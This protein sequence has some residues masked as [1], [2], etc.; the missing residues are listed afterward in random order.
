MFDFIRRFV[1]Y[2]LTYTLG[3]L[4]TL[5][6]VATATRMETTSWMPVAV[7]LVFLLSLGLLP[8]FESIALRLT[9]VA[10]FGSGALAAWFLAEP[11]AASEPNER[12][13]VLVP[14]IGSIGPILCGI[15]LLLM[16]EERRC[17]SRAVWAWMFSLIAL[18][19]LVS[20]YST[21]HDLAGSVLL[22]HPSF[23]YSNDF[24]ATHAIPMRRWYQAVFYTVSAFVA[25]GLAAACGAPK[26]KRLVFA[27]IV[28]ISYAL[29]D[30]LR[31]TIEFTDIYSKR[32]IAL[33]IGCVFV[34]ALIGTRIFKNAPNFKQSEPK[35]SD[36]G[37]NL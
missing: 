1:V 16:W 30:E 2:G 34:A 37:N 21:M 12:F 4:A 31:N 22:P 29:F 18:G 25:A 35:T 9:V 13:S 11:S 20:F 10:L 28:P 17:V 5:V 19:W 3:F 24:A 32:D 23:R 36:T 15:V 6:V 27:L 7:G 26:G 14:L 8:P 33:D